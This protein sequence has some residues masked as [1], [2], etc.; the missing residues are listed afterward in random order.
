MTAYRIDRASVEMAEHA[1]RLRIMANAAD[2]YH[3]QQHGGTYGAASEALTLALAC[4]IAN[5]S[6]VHFAD[7]TKVARR[8]VEE[9][10]D[11]GEDVTYQIEKVFA[12]DSGYDMGFTVDVNVGE[13]MLDRVTGRTATA[14]TPPEDRVTR[15][16]WRAFLTASIE[17]EHSHGGTPTLDDGCGW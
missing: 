10:I 15:A 3:A 7:A 11:N 8:I 6:K 17:D 14:H 9:V 1:N 12:T 16:V 4:G 2:G 13:V 5:H